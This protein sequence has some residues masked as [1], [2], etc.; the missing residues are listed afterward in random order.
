MSVP[1]ELKYD[2][3]QH[4]WVAIDDNTATIG[5]TDYAQE[6]MGDILF[7]E[8]AE[9]DDEFERGDEFSVVESG[10]KASP[11]EAPF[12]FK[13]LEANEVL[14]DEPEAINEDAYENWILKVQ[15]TDDEG[16]GDLVDAAEYE[17]AIAE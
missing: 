2:K 14:D 7:V 10:K 12:A 15:I 13:V 1:Q 9:E 6:K 4:I 8:L 16:I 17:A 3:E 5:I 11:L